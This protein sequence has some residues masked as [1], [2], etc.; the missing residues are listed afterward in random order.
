MHHIVTFAIVIFGLP[1][2]MT[3]A[4][5]G[6]APHAGNIAP[7]TPVARRIEIDQAMLEPYRAQTPVH[8]KTKPSHS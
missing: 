5:S 1:E 8:A 2:H 4:I 3:L 7:V 6:V